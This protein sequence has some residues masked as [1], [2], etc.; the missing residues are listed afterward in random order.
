MSKTNCLRAFLVIGIIL[1]L[2][3]AASAEKEKIVVDGWPAGDVAFKAILP[4]FNKAYPDI[5]VT[6]AFQK[7]EDHHQQLATAIAAGS[8]APD[9]AM[10]EQQWIG[11][12]KDSTGLENLL[13]APYSVGAM[14]KD[15]VGYKW[16]LATS[17]DGKKV[18]PDGVVVSF[19]QAIG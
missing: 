10:I 19:L 16:D 13:D 9:V 6:L 1:L 8:G 5:E 4:D 15:F 3:V 17:I 18:D 12:Y 11:K 14:K 2:P 7:I